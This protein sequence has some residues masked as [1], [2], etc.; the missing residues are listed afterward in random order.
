MKASLVNQSSFENVLP[1]SSVSGLLLFFSSNLDFLMPN[2]DW[3]LSLRNGA[4][5]LKSPGI[6]ILLANF[7]LGTS[8]GDTLSY[9]RGSM[10]LFHWYLVAG[11]CTGS[12]ASSYVACN[13]LSCS[14]Y[15]T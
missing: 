6:W 12:E 1:V 14:G 7:V 13:F 5:A 4:Q 2:C 11:R 3:V 10:W 8:I 9:H 15:K